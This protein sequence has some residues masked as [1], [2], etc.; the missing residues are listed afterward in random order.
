MLHVD[1]NPNGGKAADV[2][3]VPTIDEAMAVIR[4]RYPNAI[5]RV[6]WDICRHDLEERWFMAT[7]RVW[8]NSQAMELD[9]LGDRAAAIIVNESHDPP[10][11]KARMFLGQHEIVDESDC[12]HHDDE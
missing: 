4:Q 10:E 9:D 6:G 2:V 11:S 7:L 5:R 3:S 12:P 8:P 1:F